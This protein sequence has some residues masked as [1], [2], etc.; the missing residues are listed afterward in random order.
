MCDRTQWWV[1]A[2]LDLTYDQ[3]A[4]DDDAAPRHGRRRRRDVFDNRV[5]THS[6]TGSREPWQAAYFEYWDGEVE[7]ARTW[8]RTAP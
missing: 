6:T 5:I 1:E 3:I 7:P 8:Q 4:V 2:V